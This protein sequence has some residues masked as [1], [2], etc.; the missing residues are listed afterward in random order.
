MR[1]I[2]SWMDIGHLVWTKYIDSA[3]TSRERAPQLRP[4]FHPVRGRE[5]GP[6]IRT[7]ASNKN[8]PQERGAHV[9]LIVV[10]CH[11]RIVHMKQP[12]VCFLMDIIS[13]L[14]FL[15]TGGKST[16][17]SLSGGSF[18]SFS[19]FYFIDNKIGKI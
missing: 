10:Y 3:N 8:R 19:L 4:S 15:S 13:R 1:G 5:G 12:G 16:I 9:W 17:P 11:S 18:I 2:S 6:N 7:F 14:R